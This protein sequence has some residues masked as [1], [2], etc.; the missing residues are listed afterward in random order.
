MRRCTTANAQLS[1]MPRNLSACLTSSH[2]LH[3]LGQILSLKVQK[4]GVSCTL[5]CQ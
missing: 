5:C 2:L 1:V 4:C 3:Y